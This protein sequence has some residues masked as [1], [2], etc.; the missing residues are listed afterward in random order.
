M[1]DSDILKGIKEIAE[2]IGESEDATWRLLKADKLPAYRFK[3]RGNWRMKK[4]AYD[5]FLAAKLMR[6]AA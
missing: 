6:G 5:N 3:Q 1:T 2:F 4:S